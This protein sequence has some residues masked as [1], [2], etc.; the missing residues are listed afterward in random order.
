MRLSV[1]AGL[2]NSSSRGGFSWHLRYIY[3]STAGGGNCKSNPSVILWHREVEDNNSHGV[4]PELPGN[5]GRRMKK[6]ASPKSKPEAKQIKKTSIDRGRRG[7]KTGKNNKQVCCYIPQGDSRGHSTSAESL[8]GGPPPEIGL[9][10]LVDTLTAAAST[11]SSKAMQI[12]CVSLE[13]TQQGLERPLDPEVN[14]MH[15]MWQI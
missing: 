2:P 5:P 13:Y 8:R 14:S 11:G 10:T 7:R 1:N 15:F 4:S 9:L 3:A 6:G 12:I